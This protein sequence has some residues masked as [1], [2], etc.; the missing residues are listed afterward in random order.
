MRQDAEGPSEGARQGD[1]RGS[2]RVGS[3]GD[4]FQRLVLGLGSSFLPAFG[5]V[6]GCI[7]CKQTQRTSPSG[8]PCQ[9]SRCPGNPAARPQPPAARLAPSLCTGSALALGCRVPALARTEIPLWQA[10]PAPLQFSAQPLHR[11]WLLLLVFANPP[12]FHL[13]RAV[14]AQLGLALENHPSTWVGRNPSTTTLLSRRSLRPGQH[15]GPWAG[16]R[17]QKSPIPFAGL[18]WPGSPRAAGGH[19]PRGCDKHTG[20]SRDGDAWGDEDWARQCLGDL[21]WEEKPWGR[22]HEGSRL[23]VCSEQTPVAS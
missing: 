17:A 16:C 19:W 18:V 20:S 21:G 11:S 1:H 9:R 23:W 22:L 7:S 8:Q 13:R 12:S 5:F 10:M 2:E 6:T 4:V 15:A 14:S 3:Y